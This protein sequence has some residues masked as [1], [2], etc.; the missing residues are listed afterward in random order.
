ME[1]IVNPVV[2]PVLVEMG[3]FTARRKVIRNIVFMFN[4]LAS[5][6]EPLVLEDDIP[7]NLFLMINVNALALDFI[8]VGDCGKTP[9]KIVTSRSKSGIL[10]LRLIF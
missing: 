10:T 6:T 8:L 7:S 5:L 4:S 1:K 3:W 2:Y 9:Q